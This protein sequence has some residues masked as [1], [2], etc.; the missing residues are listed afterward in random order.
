MAMTWKG[1]DAVVESLAP[2]LPSL[3]AAQCDIQVSE[4][5]GPRNFEM[6]GFAV[7]DESPHSAAIL[8][9]PD[10]ARRT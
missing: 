8:L 10:I 7:S 3:S 4:K 6:Q 5:R 9:N 2:K 1:R